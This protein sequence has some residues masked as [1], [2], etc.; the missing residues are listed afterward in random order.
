MALPLIGEYCD[1]VLPL[2]RRMLLLLIGA[3]LLQIYLGVCLD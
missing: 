2:A 1:R 3:P